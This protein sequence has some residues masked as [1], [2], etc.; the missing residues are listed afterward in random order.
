MKD[1]FRPATEPIGM[2]WLILVL[3][4]LWQLY[5]RHWSRA[6]A[7]GLLVVTL[8]L[9]GNGTVAP[10]LLATLE[11]PYAGRTVD[12]LAPADAVVMLGGV[13]SLSRNDRF[14]FQLGDAAD[15]FVTAA[16]LVRRAKARALILGGG[17]HGFAG[18]RQNEGDLLKRWLTTWNVGSVPVVVLGDC[19]TTYD[20]AQR[21][22]RVLQEKG[23]RRIILVTSAAHM[24]RGEALFHKLGIEVDPFAADFRGL[25]EEEEGPP[26]FSVFPTANALETLALYSHE[27]IGWWVYKLRG[28][29]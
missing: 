25:S 17:D 12:Q 26:R 19:L 14:G 5:R 28:W 20:E 23:W 1:F 16:D 18:A 24:R 27:V 21:T 22:Q 6:F 2:F 11:R 15:R 4:M 13:V 7:T 9:I 3:W 8:G 29:V 10:Q